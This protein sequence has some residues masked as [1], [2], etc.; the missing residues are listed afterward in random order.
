MHASPSRQDRTSGRA[1]GHVSMPMR[2]R[3]DDAPGSLR[4]IDVDLLRPG[5]YQPR[6]DFPPEALAELAASIRAEGVLQPILVRPLPGTAP[7]RYEIIAGERRWRAAQ[8][9]GLHRIPALVRSVDDHTALEQA[10]VENLQRQDLNPV[11]TARG[12]ARLIEVFQLTHEEAARRLGRSRDAVSHL[13]RILRLEPGVLAAVAQ[14]RLSVGHAKLLAGLPQP[15][16]RQLAEEV[17]RKDLPVRA[18]ERRIRGLNSETEPQPTVGGRRD[19]DI[20][21]LE[22]RV[23][24]IVGAETRIDYESGKGRGQI[25]FTFYT[26]EA[27]DGI[28]ERLGYPAG[29]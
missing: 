12:I 28:L 20:V 18:L 22:Q 10:L 29:S 3:F 11:E 23:G 15:T 24:E 27:L 19:P 9:A 25:I 14:G 26:L 16:Q 2:Q 1:G 8:S 6:R 5:R 7:Q 13:L 21:R 17:A 4:L